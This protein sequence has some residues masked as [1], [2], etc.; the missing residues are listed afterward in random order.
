MDKNKDIGINEGTKLGSNDKEDNTIK[1]EL[2]ITAEVE[3]EH[4]VDKID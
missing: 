3:T 4:K 1:T 2:G